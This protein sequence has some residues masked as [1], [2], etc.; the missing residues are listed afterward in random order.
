GFGR[1]LDLVVVGVGWDAFAG[2]DV[3][4]VAG[5]GVVEFAVAGEAVEVGGVYQGDGVDAV[6]GHGLGEFVG[7]VAGIGAEAEQ[8]PGL[9]CGGQDVLGVQRDRGYGQ[10][11]L[12]GVD[13][14]GY[15]A[16]GDDRDDVGVGGQGG[17][18]V[19]GDGVVA[20]VVQH[21]QLHVVAGDLPLVDLVYP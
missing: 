16:G 17:E 3:D 20:A 2:D 1:G 7:V 12:A 4:V 14:A 5:G 13:E 11:V 8:P 10:V 15:A 9:W 21:P 18:V 19:G 6:V